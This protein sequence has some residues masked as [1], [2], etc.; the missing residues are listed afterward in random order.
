MNVG[1][2]IEKNLPREPAGVD[3]WI[4]EYCSRRT[5]L[6]FSN[7]EDRAICTVCGKEMRTYGEFKHN[8]QMDC[9]HCGNGAI[10][11]ASGIGRKNITDEF[12]ILVF[13]RKGKTVWACCFEVFLEYENFGRP[14]IYKYLREVFTINSAEQHHYRKEYSW[15]LDKYIWNE[16]ETMKLPHVMGGM[17]YW[18]QPPMNT[19]LIYDKNLEKVF[20]KSDLRYIYL[21]E[22]ITGMNAYEF[23]KYISDGA[24]YQSMEL[25]AKAGFKRIVM[26]R[27]Q[28]FSGLANINWRG[29]SLPKILRLS[30]G[31]I[32]RIRTWDINLTELMA[33]QGLTSE[34]RMLVDYA[35][36]KELSKIYMVQDIR[37]HTSLLKFLMYSQ[38]QKRIDVHSWLDYIGWAERFGMDITNKKVLFPKDFAKEHD[39]L[40][41]DI[42]IEE[43]KEREEKL[44]RATEAV[45][46][47]SYETKELVIKLARTQ[48]SLTNESEQ[49]GHCVRTYGE[50]VAK[51]QC[52]I[53]FIRKK[54]SPGKSYYTLETKPNGELVQ[55]RGKSNCG[56]TEEVQEFVEGFT[57]YLQKQIKKERKTA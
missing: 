20:L 49:L 30:K 18:T 25:L 41:E 45:A 35:T 14:T 2:Y 44:K 52:Y 47:V 23:I 26:H 29:K 42:R 54:A 40:L 39:R 53:F 34:E 4:Y 21:P 38:K 3:E 55:C 51:G 57:K 46:K 37:K 17:Q 16:A 50:R 31:E 24:K 12:R 56:T 15:A 19:V 5:Y 28:G 6:I 27:V 32:K 10:M 7:K 43:N 48:K 9:P 33:F 8:S 13:T 22:L 1:E 36:L 11:K